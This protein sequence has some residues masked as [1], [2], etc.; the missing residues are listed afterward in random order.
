M[1]IPKGNSGI[2][3]K[4]NQDKA[5]RPVVKPEMTPPDWLLEAFAL[6]GILLMAG[7][8]IYKYPG[9]PDIIPS[10]FNGAGVP[11]DYSSKSTVW[12]FTGIGVFVYILLS[13]IAMIPNQF[14]YPIKITP[15]NA[16]KQYTMALRLI[17]Y[18]KAVIIWLFAYISY[19]I[20]KVA[21]KEQSGLGLWFL[22]LFLGIMFIPLIYYIIKSFK[23][24]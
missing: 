15:A 16:L 6:F 9:L 5:D 8:V 19:S 22:P 14:N 21:E 10:H 12:I 23:H 24:R 4:R 11:D 13:F 7:F 3:S 20:V 17:R 18:L 2:F 1:I